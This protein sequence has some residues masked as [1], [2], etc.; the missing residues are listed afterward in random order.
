MADYKNIP[1]YPEVYKLV[2]YLAKRNR[3]GLGAMVQVLAEAE[4]EK[5]KEEDARAET[6]MRE[7]SGV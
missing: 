2:Q 7:K 6:E 5:L 3:R 4:V 1:V